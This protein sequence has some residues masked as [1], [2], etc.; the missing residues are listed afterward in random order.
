VALDYRSTLYAAVKSALEADATIAAGVKPGCRIWQDV[1]SPAQRGIHRAPN[2]YPQLELEI[3]SQFDQLPAPGVPRTFAMAK[4][5]FTSADCDFGVPTMQ[6]LMVTLRTER[7]EVARQTPLEAAITRAL[8][9]AWPKYGLAYVT[10]CQIATS[11]NTREKTPP[12]VKER[13]VAR[14]RLTFTLW[15]KLSQLTA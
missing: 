6:T 7:P 12:D 9:K 3:A 1:N 2:D 5:G 11:R 15:P 10:G 14:W 4:V 13:T 8:M